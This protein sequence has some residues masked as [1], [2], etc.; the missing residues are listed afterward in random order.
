VDAD[1]V[2]CQEYRDY[3]IDSG[4]ALFVEGIKIQPDRGTPIINYPKQHIKNGIEK[5]RETKYQFKRMVRIAKNIRVLMED[6]GISSANNISSFLIESLF[7]NVSNAAYTEFTYYN[8]YAFNEV[9]SNLYNN[10]GY[11][12][13][14]KEI[15]GIKY[16]G[17]D[18]NQRVSICRAFVKDLKAFYN[19]S[20]D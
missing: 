11:L 14:F 12:N 19:Y 16:I 20:L 1:V 4:T 13:V 7:W 17:D 8:C 15:N 3:T 6:A 5:N 2:P 18:D 9:L 10:I